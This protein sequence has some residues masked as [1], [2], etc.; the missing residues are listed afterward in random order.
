MAQAQKA[1]VNKAFLK[2]LT[3]I[4]REIGE[5]RFPNKERL[6]NKLEVSTK[7]IQRD[8]DFM[9][10]EYD[11]PIEFNKQR[12][13]FYYTE[14]KYRLNPI[15]IDSS[16]LLALAV[17]EKVL[18]Q[19]KNSPYAKYFKNFYEKL[20]FLFDKKISIDAKDLDSIISFQIGPVRSINELVMDKITMAVRESRR[21]WVKYLTGHSGIVSDREIDIYHIKNHQGDWYIIGYCHKA[22]MIK[23]FAVS[24]IQEI[25]LTNRYFDIPE[26][27]S[28]ESYFKDSFGIFESKV[29]HNVKL[30]VM[31]E[32]VRYVKERE[33]HKSQKITQ[34]KDGSIYLEFRVNNLTEVLMWVLS[35]GKDCKVIQPKLLI[36]DIKN[37]LKGATSNYQ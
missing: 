5:K 14:E 22:M 31:N 15:K 12:S 6:A 34:L 23:V 24:R 25:K 27:F 21:V 16:D 10:F 30:K 1:T 18:E 33:W 8:I 26:D 28:I 36:N 29:V 13:G 7:T 4:D 2:R 11:A 17:T 32:S 37:E 9:K 19:Y 35:M 3:V 20:S